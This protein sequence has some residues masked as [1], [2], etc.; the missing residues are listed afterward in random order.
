MLPITK[1][2]VC[3]VLNAALLAVVLTCI[4]A[5]ATDDD[6]PYFHVGPHPDFVLISVRI[7]TPRRYAALLTLIAGMN[8]VKVVV[9]ELGEPVLVFNVYNPDK[10]IV[11]DFTRAQLLGYA[12]AMFFVSNVRRV[13]EVMITVTQFDIALFSIVVEQLASMAT[14][15]YLVREK[16]FAVDTTTR[17]VPKA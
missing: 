16:A 12:N 8:C 5:L 10:R 7:D 4:A 11:T 9:A 2:R 14:V 6:V 15:C 3:L 1:V 17:L 13:F